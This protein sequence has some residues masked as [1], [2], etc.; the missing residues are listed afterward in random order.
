MIYCHLNWKMCSG[1]PEGGLLRI[2]RI[3]DPKKTN[4]FFM[5]QNLSPQPPAPL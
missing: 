2:L 1:F 5:N 4:I 3:S